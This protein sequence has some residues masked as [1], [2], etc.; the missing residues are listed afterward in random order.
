MQLRIQLFAGL[1]ERLQTSV[2]NFTIEESSIQ[3]DQLK[4]KLSEAYPE[5]TA[6]IAVSF[7]AVNQEYAPATTLITQNDEIAL[8]PP[9]SG[10]DGQDNK[11][12]QSEDGLYSIT[13]EPLSIEEVTS[14]VLHSNHGATLSFIGTTREMTGA[15]RTVHLE[16]EAYI[17]MALAQLQAIGK[18]LKERWPDAICAISHRIGTVDIQGI[19]VIIAVSTGHRDTCYQASRF[20]IEQLKNTVP[21]WKKEIWEDGSEW[22]GHQTGPWD[23]TTY[24]V[25]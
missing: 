7:L 22:K 25:I 17:P 9:V 4:I 8:I 20:A 1:A 3:A 24:P 12:V 18:E 5:A 21:I 16:Y 10:G 13:E 2:L 14:K 11:T 6:Q 19:S 23:P 15:Q